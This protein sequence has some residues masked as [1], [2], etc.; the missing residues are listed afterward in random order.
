MTLLL[1]LAC[2]VVLQG[3]LAVTSVGIEGRLEVEVS[4]PLRPRAVLEGDEVL[5]RVVAQRALP[6]GNHTCELAFLAERP[7]ELDLVEFL[8]DPPAELAELPVRVDS[9]LPPDHAGDPFAGASAR[10]P[11]YEKRGPWRFVLLGLWAIPPLVWFVRWLRRPRPVAVVP[12]APPTVAERLEPLLRLASTGGL[13]DAGKA[14]LDRL[15]LEIWSRELGLVDVPP[16][17]AIARIRRDPRAGRVLTEVERW[18]HSGR[19]PGAD[20][21]RVA[22]LLE[23]YR[24]GGAR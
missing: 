21:A 19:A 23:P 17:E 18:L 22:E 10:L 13:D 11:R 15:M 20:D 8:E 7:G 3:P 14:R 4:A 5:L 16:V 24:G 6:N 12:P 1:A 2:A 9:I